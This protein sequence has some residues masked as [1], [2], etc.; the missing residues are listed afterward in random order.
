MW[1]VRQVFVVKQL[2]L[3]GVAFAQDGGD[4]PF[5]DAVKGERCIRWR[6]HR[7]HRADLTVVP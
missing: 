1:W 7:L 6:L 3:T 5:L 2:G 4:V